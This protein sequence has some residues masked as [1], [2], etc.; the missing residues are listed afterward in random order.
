MTLEDNKASKIQGV[1]LEVSLDV[2]NAS[3]TGDRAKGSGRADLCDAGTA[4]STTSVL[5]P[6][7]ETPPGG[8]DCPID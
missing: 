6:V 4:T 5:A 2:T 3:L 7:Q 1:G 8:E